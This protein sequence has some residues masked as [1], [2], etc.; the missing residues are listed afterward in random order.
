[1]DRNILII[2]TFSSDLVIALKYKGKVYEYTDEAGRTHSIKLP[3]CADD[4]LKKAG[5]DISEMDYFGAVTGP[6]SFTGIRIGINL[7]KGFAF[8]LNRKTVG[9]SVSD[10]KTYNGLIPAAEHKIEAGEFGLIPIYPKGG[11][12]DN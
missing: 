11:R 7:I 10:I 12:Y 2:S 5:A 4:I 8:A 1:M 3:K 6:G 9:V